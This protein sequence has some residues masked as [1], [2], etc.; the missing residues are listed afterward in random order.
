MESFLLTPNRVFLL[1]HTTDSAYL[2]QVPQ[3][4]LL[5]L[6]D[7]RPVERSDVTGL[8]SNLCYRENVLDYVLLA[9]LKMAT[10]VF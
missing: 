8:Y 1:S 5:Q 9:E 6:V 4:S 7:A 3:K 10:Q 2:F